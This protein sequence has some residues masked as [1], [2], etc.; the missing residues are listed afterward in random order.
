[1]RL[2]LTR[3]RRN[4]GRVPPDGIGPRRYPVSPG[5]IRSIGV[6]VFFGAVRIERPFRVDAMV[7]L[8]DHLHAVWTPLP[9]DADYT[10]WISLFKR[11]VSQRLK[12]RFGPARFQSRRKRR[13]SGCGNA[14][15]G[16]SRSP[17]NADDS[18]DVDYVHYN[19]DK[20]GLG[21]RVYD[22]PHS[23]FHRFV[24]YFV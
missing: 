2:R 1:M 14:D 19:P 9:N 21:R 15:F 24:G 5:V 4:H 3:I 18:R 16:S 8:T 7:I 17:V 6:R 13:E 20:Q 12:G 23:A 22:W 10:T 11:R